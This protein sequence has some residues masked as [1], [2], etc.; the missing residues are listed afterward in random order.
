MPECRDRSF[1]GCDD[2]HRGRRDDAAEADDASLW[3]SVGRY[4]AAARLGV[5]SGPADPG[6]GPDRTPGSS[7]LPP[8]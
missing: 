7:G 6:E 4:R 2:S 8:G 1:Q 3:A 5:L